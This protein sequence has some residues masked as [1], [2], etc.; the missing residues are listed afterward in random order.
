MKKK[1]WQSCSL[2]QGLNY[3]KSRSGPITGSGGRREPP[4]LLAAFKYILS[5]S[6]DLFWF[7]CFCFGMF[8]YGSWTILE[9]SIVIRFCIIPHTLCKIHCAKHVTSLESFLFFYKKLQD[10]IIWIINVILSWILN[11]KGAFGWELF[12]MCV[13]VYTFYI[14]FIIFGCS[15][16]TFRSNFS[17]NAQPNFQFCNLQPLKM[18]PKYS[19]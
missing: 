1:L 3:K 17:F 14:L 4:L 7:F 11:W 18:I 6:L 2:Y 16:N 13:Y 5:I 10:L 12:Y 8:F 19:D 15:S 9:L